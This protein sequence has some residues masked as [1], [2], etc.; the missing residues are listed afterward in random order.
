[1]IQ[2][3]I[4]PKVNMSDE[5]D[6]LRLIAHRSVYAHSDAELAEVLSSFPVQAAAR[7]IGRFFDESHPRSVRS[8][9]SSITNSA[10]FQ[11]LGYTFSLNNTIDPSM[12]YGELQIFLGSTITAKIEELTAGSVPDPVSRASDRGRSFVVNHSWAQDTH[13]G[14]RTTVFD[15]QLVGGV[16]R[17]IGSRDVVTQFSEH[18]A[19]RHWE[20]VRRQSPFELDLLCLDATFEVNGFCEYTFEVSSYQLVNPKR[21]KRVSGYR[22]TYTLGYFETA[23]DALINDLRDVFVCCH[24]VPVVKIPEDTLKTLDEGY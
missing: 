16:Y 5:Y 7:E 10:V 9:F 12:T 15:Y 20:A 6:N 23:S 3:I 19:D 14:G 2:Q 13:W 18:E 11:Y 22:N 1:M 4:F 8:A 21:P 17:P 24:A